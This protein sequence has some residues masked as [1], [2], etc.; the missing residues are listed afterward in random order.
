MKNITITLLINAIA[1][2]IAAFPQ[3][4]LMQFGIIG[5]GR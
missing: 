5:E 1:E 4:S 2:L 3:N